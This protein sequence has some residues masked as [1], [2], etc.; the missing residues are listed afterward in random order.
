MFIDSVP[1]SAQV[2]LLMTSSPSFPI[3]GIGPL[4]EIIFIFAYVKDKGV[5]QLHISAGLITHKAKSDLCVSSFIKFKVQG[6]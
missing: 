6:A 4:H 1:V 2:T 3:S 5:C